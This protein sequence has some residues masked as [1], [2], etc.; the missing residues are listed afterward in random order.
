[1]IHASIE[2]ETGVKSRALRMDELSQLS[3][4]GLDSATI[5]EVK[6]VL[7]ECDTLRFAPSVDDEARAGLLSRAKTLTKKLGA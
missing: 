4:A 5:E 7:G 6:A 3:D 1:M 2:I